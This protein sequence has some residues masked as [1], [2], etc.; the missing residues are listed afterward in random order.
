MQLQRHREGRSCSPFVSGVVGAGR[1]ATKEKKMAP[2]SR[3]RVLASLPSFQVKEG[4]ATVAEKRLLV[5]SGCEGQVPRRLRSPISVGELGERRLRHAVA[6]GARRAPFAP[7]MRGQ[8]GAAE[9]ESIDTRLLYA[10]NLVT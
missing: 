8:F 4:G 6:P 3:A 1:A 7:R 2:L 5:E 10:L 9:L